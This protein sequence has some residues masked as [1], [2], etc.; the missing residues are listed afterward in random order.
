MVTIMGISGNKNA[1]PLGNIK[2]KITKIMASEP[3]RVSEIHI[4]MDME[5]SYPENQKKLLETAALNCPVA[6]SIHPAIMQKIKFIYPD[7]VS[8]Y[9]E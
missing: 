2:M 5:R 6:K 9:G 4:E 7:G 1:I 3:R 8:S